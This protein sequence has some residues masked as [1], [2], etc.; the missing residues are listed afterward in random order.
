[1]AVKLLSAEIIGTAKLLAFKQQMRNIML[2]T[3]ACSRVCRLLAC[4]PMQQH[5]CL[6]ML[7]YDKSLAD[8][9]T[10]GKPQFL[11]VSVFAV[12]LAPVIDCLFHYGL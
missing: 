8:I 7:K 6:V 4:Y 5:V 10:E 2:A 3:Q 1:M 11:L 12:L 9:L